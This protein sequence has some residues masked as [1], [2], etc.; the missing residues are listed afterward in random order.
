LFEES[1]LAGRRNYDCAAMRPL[2]RLG[3]LP[4][5]WLYASLAALAPA[6]APGCCLV[7]PPH[8]QELVDSGFRSPEQTFR[9]LKTALSA[10]LADLEYRCLSSGF[11]RANSL[12]Q[13]TYREAREQLRKEKP[14]IVLVAKAE[15]RESER[16]GADR[17]RIVAEVFGRS[18]ELVL[19]REDFYELWGETELLADG[20]GSFD[21]WT[22]EVES[23]PGARL[24]EAHVPLPEHAR[25]RLAELRVGREWKIDTIEELQSAKTP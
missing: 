25:A 23:S 5:A 14:W 19:V 3:E 9:T 21:Q 10:D 15:Q 13:L 18:I 6:V 24:L 20:A 1:C 7:R 2:L 11:R 8:A 16:L 17:H 12:S 4:A 22:H